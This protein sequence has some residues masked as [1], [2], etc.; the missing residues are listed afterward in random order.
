MMC[1][2]CRELIFLEAPKECPHCHA[3]IRV[4]EKCFG[5]GQIR[6]LTGGTMEHTI[7]GMMDCP[8][9]GGLGSIKVP[10]A[11]EDPEKQQS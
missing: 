4:C 8:D 6:V 1:A 5:T 7:H 3:K 11:Q 2:E 10:D 9:C